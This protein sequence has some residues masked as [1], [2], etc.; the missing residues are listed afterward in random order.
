MIFLSGY[1]IYHQIDEDV[2]SSL[3]F[4][5]RESD[6]RKVLIKISK[7]DYPTTLELN[8][9]KQEYKITKSLNFDGIIKVYALEK[10][11]NGLALILENFEGKSLK[12]L[13]NDSSFLI[14]DFLKIAVKIATILELIHRNSIIHKNLNSHN[15]FYNPNTEELKISNFSIATVSNKEKY[16]DKFI[17]EDLFIL[18]T[19]LAYISPEQTGRINHNLDY[20]TDFYSLGVTFYELLTGILP[21]ESDD[22]LKLFNF[23]ITKT[24]IN[25]SFINPSIPVVISD[26]VMKLMAKNPND[27]YQS[28]WGLKA[29]LKDCLQQLELTGIINTFSLGNNDISDRFLISQNIYDREE[30]CTNLLTKLS[31]ITEQSQTEIIFITGNSGTGKSFLVETIYQKN[32]IK[33]FIS[34]KF[35]QFQQSNPYSALINALQQFVKNKLTENQENINSWKNILL[36]KLGIN[37]QVIIDIIPELEL[38]IDKQLPLLK[39]SSNEAEI[40]FNLVFQK[41]MEACCTKEN[42]LVI[43]LDDLQWADSGSLNLIELIITNNNLPHLFLIGAYRD[44]EIN[45]NHPLTIMMNNIKKHQVIVN[46]IYLQNLSIN[47]ITF[48][49]AETLK[50]DIEEVKFL[51]E[52][53]FKKTKGNPFFTKQFLQ[54]LYLENFIY[55]DYNQ[56]KWQWD[57]VN[58]SA[59]N[60]TDNVAELMIDQLKN[61]PKNTQSLLKLSSCLGNKFDLLTLSIISE[62]SLEK[63]LEELTIAINYGLIVLLPSEEKINNYQFQFLHDRVQQAAYT[64]IG[65]DE[66]PKIHLKIGQL[67]L[68]KYTELEQEEHLFD[69]VE[70]WNKG[71]SLIQNSEEK[72]NLITLNLK[73]AKKAK[74]TIAYDIAKIYLQTGIELLDINCWQNQYDLTLNLYNMRVEIAYLTS[75][76]QKMQIM[77]QKVLDNAR[78]ILDKILIYKIFIAVQIAKSRM[79]LAIDVGR[80]ALK[81]LGIQ[82]PISANIYDTNNALQ[83]LNRQLENKNIEELINLPINNNPEG[84]AIL[85]ILAILYSPFFQS[86][87]NIIPWVSST[88]VSLSIKFGNLSSSAIGYCIHGMVLCSFFSEVNKGYSFGKLAMNLI[89]IDPQQQFQSVIVQIFGC[90]IQCRQEPIRNSLITLKNSHQI[91]LET[92]DLVNVGYNALIYCFTGFFAGVELETLETELTSYHQ[93]STKISQN[94]AKTYLE[95]TWQTIKNLRNISPQPDLLRGIL[96]DETIKITYHESHQEL[97]AI[98]QVY[99]Y[100]LL[101][102]YYFGNYQSAESYINQAQPHLSAVS[103]IVFFPYYYYYAALTYGALWETQDNKEEILEKMEYYQTILS[104]WAEDTPIN[105]KSKWHLVEAEKQRILNNKAKAIENYDKAIEL[106]KE[107]QFINEVAMANELAGKFYL[108]W[109][110]EKLAQIYFEESLY[111]YTRWGATAKIADLQQKYSQVLS[112]ITTS[113]NISGDIHK[114]TNGINSRNNLDLMTLMK[115]SEA[116]AKEVQLENLLQTLMTI[117][118]ENAG[119]QKGCLLLHTSSSVEELGTF[120]IAIDICNNNHSLFPDKTIGETLPESI[121]YYVARTK[122]IICLDYPYLT[123]D[124]VSDSYIQSVQPFSILCYPLINQGNLIGI[125]YLEN[126]LTPGACTTQSLELL[127]LLSGQAAIAIKNS[128][129][130]HQVK[131]NEELLRQFLEAMPVAIGILDA[132]GHP[133][134]TNQ[135]AKYILGQGVLS[136][137][138]KEDIAKTYKIYVSG[139]NQLYPNQDLPVIK[140]LEGKVSSADDI[141]IHQNGQIIPVE[142]WA[143]PIYDELG[144]ILFAMVAFQD[145]AQ[146]KEIEKKLRDYHRT[147]EKE[148]LRRTDELRKANQQLSRLANLDG[149]TQVANRRHFDNYLQKEWQRHLRQNKHLSLILI[150]ID[151][152]KPYNDLYGHQKGDDCLIKVAQTISSVIQRPTDLFARY[153]GEEFAII[154]PETPPMGAFTVAQ[155]VKDAINELQI[156]H[157][158]SS[159]NKYVTLSIGFVSLIPTSQ[160]TPENLITKTDLALYQA[161]NEGRNRIIGNIED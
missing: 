33:N 82:L 102:A 23:H 117:L 118:M 131:Q 35:D 50:S 74:K 97:T 64:L 27:R 77:A 5:V 16:Q 134:Y 150:D 144:E 17:E 40:R 95:M 15:I 79:N 87:P 3:Y 84:E 99:I 29:D 160:L 11:K 147:L 123:G 140:A 161:K 76:F 86:M 38:I 116:I 68:Q 139:T 41:F 6:Q 141:E 32:I 44:N 46:E 93:L 60:I 20:R 66:K 132:N 92:G 152:F 1:Q 135:K 110:K 133:Y 107:N 106:A 47:N 157:E 113:S 96:Y 80:K 148:V 61:F 69:I 53:I 94:S 19:R 24:P 101:L 18:Q 153:G 136:N 143:T 81:E 28:A 2:N 138:L 52:L 90:I 89:E 34:G 14:S 9:Y 151:Y 51:S 119:V 12:L 114:T 128:Q 56:Y 57:I 71:K 31:N 111:Y 59:Q 155:S 48:L 67:L 4:G 26:L 58:I 70:H 7:Q 120:T 63:I 108:S 78:N 130:Y 121:F 36:K 104:Q 49:I 72:E 45:G 126:N 55:F 127:Q 10:Y 43:F 156:I 8:Q 30:I 142:C 25:P 73:V 85:E 103:G 115:A 42:P 39:I 65:E 100:K 154:L 137:T 125:V 88:M 91:A 146:R 75:D 149:L 145:I 22:S 159:V 124:F 158:Q 21:F 105:Y 112:S 122:E 37:G 129:L 62:K 54:K 13:V 98:A 109:K 83:N